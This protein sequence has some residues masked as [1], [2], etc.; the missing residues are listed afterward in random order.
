MSQV[1]LLP[2]EVRERQRA[3]RR[4]ALVALAGALA[5]AIVVG[6]SALQVVGL[7]RVE[8][9]LAAQERVNAE[10]EAEVASLQ[11]FADLEAQLQAQRQLVDAVFLGEVSFSRVLLD[12]SRT[13]PDNAFLTE[14]SA[15]ITAPTQ[16]TEPGAVVGSLSFSGTVG[17]IDA[18][19]AFLTRLEQVRGWVNPW[20]SN[21]Q[22][23]GPFT[24][25]YDFS[26][27][28]DLSVEALTRR[29][30]RP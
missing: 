24:G 30:G 10:L 5:L 26:A 19:A 11:E 15:Q 12:V 6:A 8:G 27:G 4:T 23:T 21:A 17:D 3:R 9:E 13:I 18:L 2:P 28:A 20:T 14:L 22:E 1:N 16:G 7:R 25:Q 29:G